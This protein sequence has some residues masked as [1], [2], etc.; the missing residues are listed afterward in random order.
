MNK[1]Q[2]EY[3]LAS[4]KSYDKQNLNKDLNIT[5]ILVTAQIYMLYII[6]ALNI[7]IFFNIYI[8]NI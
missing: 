3:F 4:M 8:Y 2:K 6:Y 7:Y 1:F 5:E